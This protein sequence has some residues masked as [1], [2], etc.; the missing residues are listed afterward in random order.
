M[1]GNI[2]NPT[3]MNV[4]SIRP[5]DNNEIPAAAARVAAH[6]FFE[7]AV[8][9]LFPESDP[10]QI[11]TEFLKIRSAEQL[12][13]GIMLKAFRRILQLTSTSFSSKGIERINPE[14]RY[15]FVSNHRDIV[16]DAVLLQMMLNNNGIETAEVTFGSNLMHDKFIADIGKMNKMF[17][18]VRANEMHDL[19]DFYR[20]SLEVSSYMRYALLAK[21]QSLW[22]AQRNGRTKDGNDHTESALLKMLSLG[23][24]KPFVE[25]IAE[26][27]IVP[28]AVSYE[29]EPCDFLKVQERY[30]SSGGHYE[31]ER[32][33]DFR[34]IV[35]GIT[36]PKGGICIEIMPPVTL[37]ELHQCD[38]FGRKQKFETLAHLI[39]RRIYGGYRLWKTNY[40]AA[41]LRNGTE[42][43][44]SMYT[45][46][47][48]EAFERYMDDGLRQLQGEQ[49]RLRG[50]FLDIYANPVGNCHESASQQQFN[51]ITLKTT[52]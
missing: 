34:S 16:L 26:L 50:L 43:Y 51:G 40:I 9:F 4:D 37:P 29:Y 48:K 35:T 19:R 21:R 32:D 6:P 28:V 22:I 33:E 23:S 10:E 11:R 1:T 3:I 13:G 8:R 25:N 14:Q 7:Q 46:A 2:Y 17:R 12:Q 39:D 36:R 15:T 42:Q 30:L 41:D 47:D 49:A 20:N 52:D 31:K 18:L 38:S 45:P 5:Y 27:N 44:R 24:G